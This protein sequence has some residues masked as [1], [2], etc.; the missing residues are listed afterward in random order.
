MPGDSVIPALVGAVLLCIVPAQPAGADAGVPELSPGLCSLASVIAE[1]GFLPRGGDL[2][3]MASA[4]GW[5]GFVSD[6]IVH[7]GAVDTGYILEQYAFSDPG[8]MLVGHAVSPDSGLTVVVRASPPMVAPTGVPAAVSVGDSVSFCLE[9]ATGGLES[10]TLAVEMPDLTVT[11]LAMTETWCTG[12]EASIPGVYWIELLDMG[13]NGPEVILLFPVVAGGTAFDVLTGDIPYPRS[14][15]SSA[16]EVLEELNGL[17]T[18]MGIRPLACDPALDSI[19]EIR[20]RG[21]ALSG[22][23]SHFDDNGNGIGDLLDG[24][25]SYGENIGRGAGF[26]EAWSMLL[27]SPL[28]LRTCLDPSF[29]SYGSGASVD[30]GRDRW[31]LVLVQVFTAE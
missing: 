21:L 31:Q 13:D 6:V 14:A 15:A 16:G 5:Y 19:G 22:S 8:A 11:D 27:I 29:A 9:G 26:D 17:R 2:L 28:H 20:A 18:S 24:S 23:T 7:P 1:Y 12:F 25:V 4:C 3:L 10:P 30:T